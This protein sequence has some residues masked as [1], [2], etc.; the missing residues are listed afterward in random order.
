MNNPVTNEKI[1]IIGFSCLFPGATTPS[2]YWHNLINGK[3]TTSPVTAAHFGA[4][5]ALYY[6][7]QRRTRDTTYAL[8]GGY[9]QA[10]IPEVD[11]LGKESAWSLYVAREG[12]RHS[13]YLNKTDV[14]ARCG[15]ILG[16]LSFPT[17]ES[18][19]LVAPTYTPVLERAIADL[20][21]M[22]DFRLPLPTGD[23][24]RAALHSPSTVVAQKLGLGGTA[25][26]IDAAC[27]SSLYAI[28]LGCAY[29]LSGEADLML[30]GAVS[31]ADPLF[32]N[33]GF[34]H[35]G[36]YPDRGQSRPLDV[37]SDGLISGEGAGMV[38]LKRYSEAVRDGDTVYAVIGG[39]GLSNDGRGKHPLTPNSRGQILALERAY[40]GGVDPRQVQY[41]ECHAS[42]T[43]LGDK[44]ELNSMDEFF[45]KNDTLPLIGSVKAN[46]GHLLTVAGLAS[47]LKVI[48]SMQHEQIPATV[49]VEQPLSSRRFGAAQI[50]RQATSWTGKAKTAGINAFGF[51]GVSAHLILQTPAAAVQPQASPSTPKARLAIVGMDAQF[52]GCVGLE[53]FAQTLYAGK[54]HFIPLPPK[55]WKGLG[56]DAPQAA[57]IDSFEIDFLRFKFPP[58]EDD[59]PTP[60]HLLLLKVADNAVL[61]AQLTED[62]NVAVIVVLETDLSLHQYRSRLDL[63]WQIKEGLARQGYELATDIPAVEQIAKDALSPHAQVNQYTSYIGNII[64]SRVS[65]LWNFSGPA[66]T[67]SA[68]ESAVYKALEVAQI[69]LAD[70]TL[71]AVVIGAV[72]LAAG[73][74]NVALR[75]AQYPINTGTVT[76][77]FDQHANGWQAGE[78]AGAVV[79][80]RADRAEGQHVYATIDGVAL[81][82]HT[83]ADSVAQALKMALDAAGIKPE[84]VG[85]VEASASGIAT[86]DEAEIAGLTRIYRQQGDTLH[87]ALGSVKANIGHTG[88]AAGIASLIKTALCLDRRF[89]PATP[90][91]STPKQPEQWAGS[92]FYVPRESQTW[93]SPQGVRRSAVISS[94]GDD[95]TCAQVVLTEAYTPTQRAAGSEYLKHKGLYLFPVDA[96]DRDTLIH[97]LQQ[98]EGAL[99]GQDSLSALAQRTY[100]AFRNGQYVAVIIARDAETLRR[101]VQ[102]AL[103]GI[104]ATF[105]RGGDWQT[106]AGSAFSANPLGATGGIAFVYPG[107]FNSYPDHGRDWLHLFPSA[108]DY[109]QSLNPN[110]GHQVGETLLYP[111]YLASP[112]RAQVK[113]ARARLMG[114]QNAIMESGV[115]F[116]LLYSHVL[117][118]VFQIKPDMAFGYSLGETSMLWALEVWRDSDVARKALRESPLFQ[119][120]LFGAKTAVREAWGLPTHSDDDFWASYILS[121]TAAAVYEQLA[122]ETRVYLTHI[123]TPLEVVIAGD[124]VA[125][126]RVIARLGCES[127]RAPFK[128]VI[129]NDAMLSEYDA[130]YQLYRRPVHA[131]KDNI[132]FYSA[133]DYEPMRLDT[134][135]VARSAARVSC[136]QVDFPRLINNTYRDGARIFIELG[137]ASTCTRWINDTLHH[138][139]REHLAVAIDQL[140]LDDH[141]ALLKMLARLVSHRV[142]LNLSPLYD[143]GLPITERKRLPRTITL[144]GDS[145]QEVILSEDN[146]RRMG[147]PS[148]RRAEPA[149][150]NVAAGLSRVG[151]DH[152]TLLQNRLSGLRDIE[153]IL[154]AQTARPTADAP[155][156]VAQPPRQPRVSPRYTPRPAIF[157]TYSLDQFARGSIKACFGEEY[158]IYDHKRAPRIP[159]TD[160]MLVS[161]IVEVNATRLVTQ[162]GSSMVGEY[163][164]SPDM[165]FFRDNPYPFTPYSMLMEIAL[166]PCGFLSA[167]MGPTLAFPDIDFYFRNL[168]GAGKLLREVDLRGRTLVNRV[169][170]V[171]S[172]T[173]Q[174]I[175]IQKYTFDMQLDGESFYVGSSTFGYFTE[176]ALASQAGLDRGKPPVKWHEAT[177]AA[178]PVRLP[179][180][181]TVSPSEA[182]VFSL[183]TGQ[184]AF[185]D[186]VLIAVEGGAQG[187]GYAYGTNN[188]HP[189]DWFFTCHFH[190]DPVMPGSLGLETVVQAIQ[191][192]ALQAGLSQGLRAPRFG[193]VENHELV[194]KYRG[195][196]LN[197]SRNVAVEVHI[198]KIERTAG[199]ILISA[200]ASLWKG[201]LRIYEF[202]NV[203][204]RIV[205]TPNGGEYV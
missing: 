180:N 187:L 167:Y 107:A 88:A 101:E 102:L 183:P 148:S 29:L 58:R 190:Q 169:E 160:L 71:D 62:S 147:K 111:R 85:Y 165:W 188:V 14:L 98:L 162:A 34:T 184:L 152:S 202:K 195:Q 38:V 166:Q 56:E 1:A 205:D 178:Q 179:G 149:L 27:A 156:I 9:I 106:P 139:G 6:D 28:G 189:S 66:F 163:D 74:E 174:G 36:A 73:I 67:L 70:G 109:A 32:V 57:Y 82:P 3:I 5:P 110:V 153:A 131:V 155:V 46:H 68:S 151:G 198:T 108:L 52:G 55:R 48:L 43:P 99:E 77:S 194:W 64:S 104:P 200:D 144:G 117:R 86:Q 45:D 136:K 118:E 18:H 112:D 31:A 96:D 61:D 13:G 113:A 90:N 47:I 33:M 172:T 37:E 140:K 65:A 95:E 19:R 91:W 2:E 40:A 105:E 164:V 89:I 173:L 129:H 24:P 78:G 138:E 80:K 94:L 97:R 159:N 83:D 161:R 192:Y 92:A 158:A 182:A 84:A 137:P 133:A 49:G 72:D 23:M 115:M 79:V 93:F 8:S 20:I 185:L 142:P 75:R 176:Q 35:F 50:V 134:E 30:T 121:A 181:R 76:L 26:C 191:A 120:R 146:R 16:S 125:C 63:S 154:K 135:L 130:F 150:T 197:D 170:L 60:Q 22:D 132:T 25:F 21:G 177:P 53:S 12:L 171:S 116:S 143:E 39:I 124:P 157:D 17:Q 4:D 87:T 69:L 59:Q 203:G 128:T 114:D 196:V 168:D 44:T 15:L 186:D 193:L 7:P 122:H 119:S 127:L 51:G 81:L 126:E 103:K 54:Q 123:N 141:T 199:A 41:V 145:V 11:E 204:V 175:I 42:G 100:A 10:H 201:T